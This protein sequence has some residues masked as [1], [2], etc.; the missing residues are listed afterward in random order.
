MLFVSTVDDIYINNEYLNASPIK[1]RYYI[2]HVQIV[3][4]A[5]TITQICKTNLDIMCIQVFKSKLL[6][7]KSNELTKHIEVQFS[8]QV[9]I[10]WYQRIRSWISPFTTSPRA[11]SNVKHL[12][13]SPVCSA[14]SNIW[15][16]GVCPCGRS[17]VSDVFVSRNLQ[18]LRRLP[19]LKLT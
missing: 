15:R 17:K 14:R 6:Q 3:R 5:F 19:S 12:L 7:T 2:K 13:V 11:V 18:T 1:K 4:H 9:D 10:I 8:K 16:W